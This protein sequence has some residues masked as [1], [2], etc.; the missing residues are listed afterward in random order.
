VASTASVDENEAGASVASVTT[1]NAG[2]ITVDDDRFEV[3][4]GNLKL[5]AGASLDFESDASPITV[6]ITAAS[7]GDGDSDTATVEVSINDVN[8]APVVNDTYADMALTNQYAVSRVTYKQEIDLDKL[9]SDEDGDIL[10][11][12][13]EG[14]PSWLTVTRSLL[15]GSST[16]MLLMEGTAP[17]SSL[18][19]TY[20][21]KIVA[22][23]GDGAMAEVAVHLIVDDGNDAPSAV[24]VQVDEDFAINENDMSGVS[25]GSVTVEDPDNPMHPHGMHTFMVSDARF[26]V[27]DGMLML[28][29][30]E[31]L[32]YEK[33]ASKGMLT[34]AITATDMGTDMM[35]G[36]AGPNA[37]KSVTTEVVIK[38]NDLD[39]PLMAAKGVEFGNWWVTVNEDLDAEDVKKGEVLSFGLDGGPDDF[40]MDEDGLTDLTLSLVGGP[41]WLEI[42]GMGKLTNKAG[43]L[44][45]R[46]VY[47]IT[48]MATNGEGD[49][50]TLPTFQLAV[51]VSDEGDEDNDE[52]SLKVDA[53]DYVEGS[54]SMA[55]VKVATIEVTDD[56][57]DIYPHPYGK[58][59]TPVIESAMGNDGE[60]YKK[61]FMVSDTPVKDGNT[62]TY[63][64]YVKAGDDGMGK[65]ALDHEIVKSIEFTVRVGQH[66]GERDNRKSFHDRDTFTIDV[67]DAQEAPF[68]VMNRVGRDN[69]DL[70][71]SPTNDS[72]ASITVEQ[73]ESEVKT[74][75]LNLT[76]ASR[77]RDVRDSADERTFMVETDADWITVKYAPM[78]Y[79]DFMEMDTNPAMAGVQPPV[80]SGGT[81]EDDHM[82]AVVEIDRMK[83]TSDTMGGKISLHATDEGG[84]TGMGTISVKVM[85]ENLA[86]GDKDKAVTISGVAMEDRVLAMAFDHTKD[87]DLRDG[88]VPAVVVYTWV[89]VMADGEEMILSSSVGYPTELLLTQKHVGMTIKASVSYYE[90]FDGEYHRASEEGGMDVVGPPPTENESADGTLSAMTTKVANV[91]DAP[92]SYLHYR[93]KDGKIELDAWRRGIHDEDGLG[94][95]HMFKWQTSDN[96]VGGWTD[97]AGDDM[98]DNQVTPLSASKYYRVVISYTDG[99]GTEE[100]ITTDP[101]GFGKVAAPKVPPTI[102]SSGGG[103]WQVGQ[104][105][106]VKN[107][108]GASVQWQKQLLKDGPWVDIDATGAE[109][110]L[111]NDHAGMTL[112]AEVA[113]MDANGMHTAL[114]A[115]SRGT[116]AA[117][118][119]A[120][121]APV[122]AQSEY[123]IEVDVPEKVMGSMTLVDQ[124]IDLDSMFY[125]ADGDML[126]YSL[127]ETRDSLLRKSL[128]SDGARA[129]NLHLFDHYAGTTSVVASFNMDTGRLTYSTTLAQSHYTAGRMQGD[130]DGN[131]VT[132]P[133]MADDG[134]GGEAEMDLVLLFDVAPTGITSART[135]EGNSLMENQAM[136]LSKRVTVLDV[137]DQNHPTHEAGQYTLTVDDARFEVRPIPGDKSMFAL[138]VKKGA[139]FDFETDVKPLAA[140]PDKGALKVMVTATQVD[141]SHAITKEV[142]VGMLENDPSD[143]PATPTAPMDD[144]MD[145][146]P[147]L[148]DDTDVNGND[149]DDDGGLPPPPMPP[150]M[151]MSLGLIDDFIDNM[152]GSGQDLIEDFM[153][154]I[155]DGLDIA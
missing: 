69:S 90:Y 39:D 59:N 53:M 45:E 60:E 70:V 9:F 122:A 22:T 54:A 75:Y 135:N 105:L 65:G 14:A 44:P 155:D 56:D 139:K 101:V 79:E 112:R 89:G 114:V 115:T 85:D 38:I 152:D 63:D 116:V 13:V 132:L 141:G 128:G 94:D 129:G 42:D 109:L 138:V 43:M 1:E 25:I 110:T 84:L 144:N 106:M 150:G 31:H 131:T 68:W 133:V 113:Y 145:G 142:V 2:S 107:A 153:L 74:L 93:T 67:E 47:D 108:D 29:E 50:A 58:V 147:G 48:I 30:G 146:A 92:E 72:M 100:T 98:T 34:L 41:A 16:D 151:S 77:D 20:N 104:T 7:S 64:V 12:T 6:T 82:V 88:D 46:G 148:V 4:G 11:Y 18:P 95:G 26:E 83:Y 126:T 121:N 51:A 33:D 21:M 71:P 24:A 15:V 102:E 86:I 76:A 81:P 32:N 28:K 17:A 143:D 55:K 134:K 140:N 23:D 10:T 123:V 5:K 99:Q 130:G 3:A 73:E 154:V 103:G 52:P 78:S 8:E 111:T 119:S 117:L 19:A 62:W 124:I 35:K 137:Q 37:P 136:A 87:P 120:N 66:V 61:H 125:D 40:F 57:F 91:N 149:D 118:Q 36:S 80:W 97:V 27:K 49:I 127:D 96:G